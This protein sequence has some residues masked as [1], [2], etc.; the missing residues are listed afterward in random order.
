MKI[1]YAFL[2]VLGLALLVSVAQMFA[3]PPYAGDIYALYRSGYFVELE[4][5][6]GVIRDAFVE[7][8]MFGRPVSAW[9]L[10]D[11]IGARH[12]MDIRV[13]NTSGLRV[14]AP[15]E[16]G[17]AADSRV[18]RVLSD[19]EPSAYSE[20]RGGRYYSAVPVFMED[21]CRFCHDSRGASRLA[22]VISFERDFDARV[23]YGAERVVIFGM[24]SAALCLL[25]FLT[26]R[27]EPGR[28]V[29]ELFDK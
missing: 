29:K 10:L 20:I 4:R 18:M 8:K 3:L 23:Y 24:L 6:F 16:T 7:T 2:T 13:Y 17:E 12:G 5:G 25:F 26:L 19:S 14:R 28:R 27:W 1:K 11:D 21:R 9:I 22:G 15:G